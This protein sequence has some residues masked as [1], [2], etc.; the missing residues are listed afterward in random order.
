MFLVRTDR[1]PE[2]GE[3]RHDVDKKLPCFSFDSGNKL[4]VIFSFYRCCPTKRLSF[5]LIQYQVP[6]Y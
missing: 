2:I 1:I 5:S 3:F 6:V 4:L